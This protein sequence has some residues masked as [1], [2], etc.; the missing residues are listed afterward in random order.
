MSDCRHARRLIERRCDGRATIDEV[1]WL[2]RH[3]E[4]CPACAREAERQSALSTWLEELPAAPSER[5]DVERAVAQIGQRLDALALPRRSGARRPF[6]A[7]AA[8]LLA[9]LVAFWV[10]SSSAAREDLEQMRLA[11]VESAARDSRLGSAASGSSAGPL[12]PTAAGPGAQSELGVGASSELGN[13]T[14]T[15]LD[16]ALEGVADLHAPDSAIDRVAAGGGARVDAGPRE[17][18]ALALL[19]SQ[20]AIPL[21]ERISAEELARREQARE[22]LIETL[23]S[24]ARACDPPFEPSSSTQSSAAFL[25]HFQRQA[26]AL[27]DAGWPI[28]SMLLAI[29]DAPAPEPARLA[30][31]ALAAREGARVL[32][33]LERGLEREE[34]RRSALL[35]LMDRGPAAHALLA[36]L[37][38]RSDCQAALLEWMRR[39]PTAA[40]VEWIVAATEAAGAAKGAPLGVE[41]GLLRELVR[42]GPR[43]LDAAYAL[44]LEEAGAARVERLLAILAAEPAAAADLE[45]RLVRVGRSRGEAELYCRAIE[46]LQPAGGPLWLL[47]EL[48]RSR[49]TPGA[50]EALACSSGPEIPAALIELRLE[51]WISEADLQAALQRQLARNEPGVSACARGLRLAAPLVASPRGAGPG[52]AASGGASLVALP[53]VGPRVW[54][55]P[56]AVQLLLEGLVLSESSTAV[57]AILELTLCA[58]L[59]RA[60]RERALLAA[61]EFARPRH[62]ELVQRAFRAQLLPE[63]AMAA[64]SLQLLEQLGGRDAC[65]SVLDGVDGRRRASLLELVEQSSARGGA[66]ARFRLA[67]E[68]KR[69]SEGLSASGNETLQ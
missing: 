30:L 52:G 4:S 67:R 26:R 44:L 45:L 21:P 12:V 51:S 19:P 60:E 47:H 48:R 28:E 11:Q 25:A 23:A 24:A 49:Q 68:L 54:G 18:G 43:G 56:E 15:E 2:E 9:T 32:R 50:L 38:W 27:A 34:L 7:V 39:A 8:A 36:S 69:S 29:A 66:V 35:A 20:P 13:R 6:V 3:A 55:R 14:A 22:Q 40:T 58:R 17:E 37:V 1:F 5:L 65:L 57:P 42:R 63:P 31:R 10:W 61:R 41:D 33:R 46:A 62:I 53:R 59:S 16:G 64:S